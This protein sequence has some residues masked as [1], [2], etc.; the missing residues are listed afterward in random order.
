MQR[1]CLGLRHYID[2][3]LQSEMQKR[4]GALLL[5]MNTVDIP[6]IG[7]DIRKAKGFC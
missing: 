4:F 2:N 1:K 3:P 5:I 7:Q 6:L